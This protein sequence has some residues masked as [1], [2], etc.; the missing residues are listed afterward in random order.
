MIVDESVGGELLMSGEIAHATAPP[1]LS[2]SIVVP[3]LNEGSLVANFLR[4]LRERA[5]E[6]E[7][8]VVDGHRNFFD[9]V[10]A[11]GRWG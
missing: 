1:V 10:L 4:H 5:P 6:A 3:V 2:V 9:R 8:I 7:V 11:F